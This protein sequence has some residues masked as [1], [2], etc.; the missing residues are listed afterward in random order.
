MPV[1]AQLNTPYSGPWNSTFVAG[2]A[3]TLI[4][5]GPGILHGIV[6]GKPTATALT[7][8]YDGT[9][10]GGTQKGSLTT[11][12]SP[13]AAFFILLDMLCDVGIFIQTQTAD[14]DMTFLWA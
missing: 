13:G 4:K 9:T 10:S 7:K 14:Q 1:Q 5:T 12:A 11:P 3:D 8:V 2:Q 6:V